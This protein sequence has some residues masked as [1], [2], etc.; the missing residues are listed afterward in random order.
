MEW[1]WLDFVMKELNF[2]DNFGGWVQMLLK[3]AK[4]C[5]KTNGYVS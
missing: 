3:R 4:A 2:G 5:I 1:G